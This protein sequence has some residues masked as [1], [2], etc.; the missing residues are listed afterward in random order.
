MEQL[1]SDSPAVLTHWVQ[2]KG[3]VVEGI[4]VQPAG[5]GTGYG[6]WSAQVC[7]G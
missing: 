2:Q 5:D 3:G 1:A 4:A 7:H 6:L